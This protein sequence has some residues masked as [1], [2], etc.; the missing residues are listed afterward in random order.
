MTFLQTAKYMSKVPVDPINNMTGDMSPA[1]TYAY[2]YYCY[3][4]GSYPGLIL[5]Y[6]R[7]SDGAWIKKNIVNDSGAVGTDTTFICK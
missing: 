6:V 3:S 1:G 2:K 4:S 5:A 7:E